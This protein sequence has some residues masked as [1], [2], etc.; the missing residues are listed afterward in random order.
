MGIII[1][2][3]LGASEKY[4]EKIADTSKWIDDKFLHQHTTGSEGSGDFKH[5]LLNNENEL[6]N[7]QVFVPGINF[8][9]SSGIGNSKTTRDG[10]TLSEDSKLSGNVPLKT[11]VEKQ[12][13]ASPYP[14]GI[15]GPNLNYVTY[16]NTQISGSIR[17]GPEAVTS[18]NFSD[19]R[20]KLKDS[21]FYNNLNPDEK[22][23]IPNA[24]TVYYDK[25]IEDR[26]LL[27]DPGN[28]TYKNLTTFD[29][30]GQGNAS[31]NSYDRITASPIYSS[32]NG[33]FAEHNDLVK[34]GIGAIDPGTNTKNYIHFRAFLNSISDNY[35]GNW[36]SVNYIGR[37]ENFYNYTGFDRKI[38][39]SFTVAAQS[40]I[41]LI[42]M[43]KK[44]NYLASNLAPDYSEKG[45][46]RG[47]LITLTIGGYLYEQPGF[48]TGLSYEISEESPW[49]IGIPD[50]DESPF[51]DDTVKE[52]PHMIK[53]STFSFTPIH[54]FVPRK[55]TGDVNTSFTGTPERF[56]A[57]KA[58]EG[59]NHDTPWPTV[60]P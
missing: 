39:L 3:P 14:G 27:G 44:L 5:Y 19:F 34:F 23:L 18:K 26:V 2:K 13:N 42:P 43:Y 38:S 24:S 12:G 15:Y 41:E 29:G 35:T 28:P 20:S 45:Y 25:R 21:S 40:K 54:T 16:D 55:V 33:K 4:N 58:G 36:D 53:V 8:T 46:M 49:E 59:S 56:I 37:G 47:P 50:S 11:Y 22:N 10:T 30:V 7:K 52:L 32:E 31:D 48:I 6:L 1:K 17:V 51:Y 57:L 9:G 60:K